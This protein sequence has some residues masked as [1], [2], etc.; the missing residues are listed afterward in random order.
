MPDGEQPTPDGESISREQLLEVTALLRSV[1][2]N[3]D[4]LASLS[5]EERTA[6]LTAAGDVFC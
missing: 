2:E 1:A 5:V 6:L 4:R 3:K